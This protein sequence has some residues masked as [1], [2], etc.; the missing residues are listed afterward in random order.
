MRRLLTFALAGVVAQ[1]V[2]GALGMAYG[3]T[4]TSFLLAGGTAPAVASATVHLAEVGTT[5]VSGVSH[6]RIGNVSWRL[7]GLLGVPGA[8]GA[9]VGASVLTNID[10][11]SAKPWIAA[12]L[13]LLGLLVLARFTFGKT[14]TPAP[15]SHLKPRWMTPLGLTAGF[16]DAIVGG[17]GL[18]LVPQEEE[19]SRLRF[20]S[21]STL[22]A[23]SP[24][25]ALE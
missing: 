15:E 20:R 14:P 2:D 19:R 25:S 12:L 1:L 17:G 7:V 5:F 3:V 8:V 21:R 10:G 13:F 4:A 11:E 24:G 16:V 6:W 9:F 23:R 22:L 18:V